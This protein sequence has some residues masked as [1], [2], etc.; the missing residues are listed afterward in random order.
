MPIDGDVVR[1]AAET[2]A[3]AFP[4]RPPTPIQEAPPAKDKPPEYNSAP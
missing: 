3:K 1:R 2:A 4:D